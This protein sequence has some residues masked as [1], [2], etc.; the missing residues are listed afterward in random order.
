MNLF[1][2]ILASAALVVAAAGIASADSIYSTTAVVSFST[3]NSYTLTLNDFNP[4]LGT[5]TGATIYFAA[6][7]DVSTLSLTNVASTS[8][9]FN[10]NATSNLVYGSSNSA[11]SADKFTGEILDDFDTGSGPGQAQYPLVSGPITLGP[12]VGGSA[13]GAC[14]EYTPSS[15]CSSVTYTPGDIVVNNTDSVYG[16][17]TGTGLGGVFGVTKSITGADLANYTGPG[18][19]TLGG[20]TLSSTSFSGGGNNVSPSI[21][22][23]AS[24]QAEIDY[25]YTDA[26]PPSTPE[27]GTMFL[28]GSALVGLGVLGKRRRRA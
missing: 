12:G 11:H 21:V 2:R 19:F 25:T 7:E 28:L 5:L 27:P 26:V 22:T 4:S 8:E 16:F 6:S 1:R 3:D 24:F 17:T 20:S 18:T 14:P 15:S 13:V 10:F 9:T 23:T